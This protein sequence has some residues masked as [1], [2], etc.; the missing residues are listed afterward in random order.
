K[1]AA[2]LATTGFALPGTLTVRAYRCGKPRCRCRADPPRLHGPSPSGPARSTV[3]HHPLPHS[4][5]ARRLRAL[6][7]GVP[8]RRT[9]DARLA[10]IQ[11]DRA[12]SDKPLKMSLKMLNHPQH[13]G[14]SPLNLWVTPG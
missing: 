13:C 9:R 5:A 14:R 3:D 4:R 1:I 10:V 2:E 12:G 6:A 7:P 8:R 11:A